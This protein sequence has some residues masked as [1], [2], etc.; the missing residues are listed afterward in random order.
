MSN[1]LERGVSSR[2]LTRLRCNRVQLIVLDD[3][4]SVGANVMPSGTSKKPGVHGNTN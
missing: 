4:T 2:C 1:A 3:D